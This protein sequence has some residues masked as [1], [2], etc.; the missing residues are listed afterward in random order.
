MSS[1]IKPTTI[2]D[3][4][5]EMISELFEYLQLKD[6][7]TCALVNK[8]WYSIYA[9][10]KV[11]R[12]VA[13]DEDGLY[14]INS[15]SHPSRRVEDQERCRVEVYRRLIDHPLLSSLKYLALCGYSPQF[16]LNR[17]GRFEQLVHLEINT[18]ECYGEFEK[19]NL[20]LA[21]LEV[22]V[23]H[24]FN[25]NLS[26]SI[27]CPRL[28]V[29]VYDE[30]IMEEPESGELMTMLNLK[31]PEAIR[32]LETNNHYTKWLARFKNV[33][34]LLTQEFNA[35]DRATLLTL[36][37]L[38]ELRF[39][40]SIAYLFPDDENSSSPTFEEI[41]AKLREFVAAAKALRGS[42]FKFTF[43]HFQLTD[44]NVDEFDFRLEAEDRG[45]TNLT[46]EYI[47]MK[48][49]RL[50]DPDARIPLYSV[51]YNRLM[52]GLTGEFPECFFKRFPRIRQVNA[53]GAVQSPVH[54]LWFLKSLS[55]LECLNLDGTQLTQEFYDQLPRHA[56]SLVD[57]QLTEQRKEP[58]SYT[59]IEQFPRLSNLQINVTLIKN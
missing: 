26:M 10:F 8:R 36:P 16:E 17:L 3:L 32:K 14:D 33:E 27:D 34:C 7:A 6:L 39:I 22:L 29:L 46:S 54:F 2:E 13:A 28:S 37:R 4:P 38:R 41:K 59:F 51:D 43:S 15:W 35:I 47:Y 30:E 21:K 40:A 25:E 50:I 20:H 53:V 56:Q 42:N 11:K 12:L 57:L 48:N 45:R 23:F 18:E 44:T 52:A 5:S 58:L 55:S 31:Y 49:Y 24:Q 19:V 9:G 1:S